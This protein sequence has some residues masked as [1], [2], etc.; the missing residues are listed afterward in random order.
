MLIKLTE[1][2]RHFDGKKR[3]KNVKN[4]KMK[5]IFDNIYYKLPFEHGDSTF[6]N[7]IFGKPFLRSKLTFL[8]LKNPTL[9]E[10][11]LAFFPSPD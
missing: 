5:Y 7:L 8:E 1:S 3:D 6:T 2:V 9:F 4:A 10:L 11:F